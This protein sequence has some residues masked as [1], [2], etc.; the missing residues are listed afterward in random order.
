MAAHHSMACQIFQPRLF[1]GRQRHVALTRIVIVATDNGAEK[2]GWPNRGTHALGSSNEIGQVNG[3]HGA[4]KGGTCST[5][6][7]K[8]ISKY[9]I[10]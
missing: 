1:T 7:I 3:I 2:F 6:F 5:G 10:L 4:E 9:C 8:L